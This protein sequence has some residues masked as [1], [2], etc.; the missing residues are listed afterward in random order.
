M[1]RILTLAIV[2]SWA[3]LMA[4]LVEKQAR[5][6]VGDVGALPAASAAD[7]DEWFNVE[8]DGQKVGHAHRV[9]SR[10]ADGGQVFY[11]DMV[12]A[13]VMLDTPQT[14]RTAL[15]SET[16]GQ[17]ALR[18]FRFTLASPAA[19]FT[20][21]GAT[22]GQRLAVTYGPEGHTTDLAVP[23][24]EPIYL[25]STLRPRLLA[26]DLT[27][28]TTYTVPVFNPVTLR[29]EPLTA[30]IEGRETVAAPEGPVEAIRISEEHQGLRARV[31]LTKDGAVLR[32]EGS[33]GFTLSRTSREQAVAA[34][35]G[36]APVDLVTAA[37][38]PLEG[39]LEGARD[40]GQLTLRVRGA[41][42]ASIPTDPPRQRITGDVLRIDREEPPES[43]PLAA[44][45]E[46]VPA[47]VTPS[48][49][50]ESDDP[51]IVATARKVAGADGDATT[52][53][54]RLVDWVNENLAKEPSV[55]V[56][57]A[58]EVLA[59][60]RGDCNEHAVLLAALARATGIPARVVA[61][62]VFMDDAFYYHAWTE[63][64]LGRWVS[65]DAVMRQLPVDATHVK[66]VDGGP[67]RHLA[68]ASVVGRLGFAV[69]EP[70][71]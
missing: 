7:R 70:H 56:P 39:H 22:D 24:S 59:S 57:S 49:F 44:A 30:T 2:T 28:G 27:P 10:A 1:R 34:A 64:W 15:M 25:P 40:L 32:E 14:L 23:L 13:L 47:Y 68:L 16:D 33:L 20:A 31:W 61:G 35:S 52:V 62:A 4:L 37:R 60:R 65:A 71:P 26:G 58:R 21:T 17:Y 63:L 5:P 38:I 46:G 51:A 19:V 48:P 45:R 3:V 8:R 50:I 43:F 18:R 36:T 55:T 29:N 54:R 67:E 53:A 11:E 41:A 6:P 9:T 69:E 66:L 12:M 42:A